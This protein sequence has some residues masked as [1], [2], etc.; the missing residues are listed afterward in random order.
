MAVAGLLG[1]G[2][3]APALG[4]IALHLAV[5]PKYGRLFGLARDVGKERTA[6]GVWAVSV[7]QALIAA[8]AAYAMG[9]AFAWV[10]SELNRI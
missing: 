1:L 4:G 2:W 3:W 10:G 6:A 7:L 5:A 8:S 9:L